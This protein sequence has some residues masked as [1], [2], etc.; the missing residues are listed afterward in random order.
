MFRGLFLEKSWD[1]SVNHPV[2]NISF[3]RGTVTSVEML[4]NAIYFT[5]TSNAKIY[6][7]E[8]TADSIPER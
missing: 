1:W 7:I 3:G 8:L 2:V 4:N 5:L 6:D